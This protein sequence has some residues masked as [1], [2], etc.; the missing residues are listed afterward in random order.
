[1]GLGEA[2][3]VP[4]A[5]EGGVSGEDVDDSARGAVNAGAAIEVVLASAP[6]SAGAGGGGATEPSA[7]WAKRRHP[8]LVKKTTTKRSKEQL[9]LIVRKICRMIICV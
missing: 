6:A 9:R 5:A 8:G 4:V 1:M 3:V 7:D 2:L